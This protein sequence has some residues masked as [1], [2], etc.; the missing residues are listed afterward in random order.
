VRADKIPDAHFA[1][2]IS[3]DVSW[4]ELRVT[5]KARVVGFRAEHAFFLVFLDRNHELFPD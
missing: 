3:E 1:D 4:C 2:T 5:Q